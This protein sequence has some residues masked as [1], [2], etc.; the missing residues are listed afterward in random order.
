[1]KIQRALGALRIELQGKNMPNISAGIGISSGISNVG[2]LGSV[3]RM[4]YTVVGD[5]VNIAE[6]LERQT[7][8][9]DVPIIVSEVGS[10]LMP[11]VLF[12]ELDTIKVKGRSRYVTIYQPM[13]LKSQVS[14]EQLTK[15]ALHQR[16]IDYF[17][18]CQWDKAKSIFS[19]LNKN[20]KSQIYK[21]YLSRITQD[22][23][24]LSK[25]HADKY[26]NREHRTPYV[27]Y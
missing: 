15:L 17:R 23:C 13:Y 14:D 6:R 18:E 21:I 11:D 22:N 2:N 8:H 26:N 9:Y 16:A 19:Q 7:R 1:M 3:F 27:T 4:A 10:R 12:R 25:M 20:E 5:A 24:K